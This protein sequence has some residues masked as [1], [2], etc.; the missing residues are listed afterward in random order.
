MFLRSKSFL[1]PLFILGSLNSFAQPFS[2]RLKQYLSS[3]STPL[4]YLEEVKEFYTR[5]FFEVH[6]MLITV[7]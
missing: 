6:K 2:E 1:A 4:P 3:V 5:I 7:K